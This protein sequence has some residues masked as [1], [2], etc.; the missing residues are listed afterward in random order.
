[1]SDQVWDA[2]LQ[3]ERTALAWRRLGLTLL[4]IGLAVPRVTFDELGWWC[5]PAVVL[6]LGCAGLLLTAGHRRYA[7]AHRTLTNTGSLASG[8]R[9]PLTVVAVTLVVGLT[10]AA[11]LL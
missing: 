3:P 8:G 10:A 7:G 6:A 5:V 11:S 2:G 9:L 4:A 1:M